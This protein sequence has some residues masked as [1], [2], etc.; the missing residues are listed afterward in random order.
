MAFYTTSA[1]SN[2]EWLQP[3]FFPSR[4]DAVILIA[5]IRISSVL[6]TI[7]VFKKGLAKKLAFIL[8]DLKKSRVK[9]VLKIS[10]RKGGQGVTTKTSCTTLIEKRTAKLTSLSRL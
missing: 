4:I 1:F 7:P 2:Q 8:S 10:A 9:G 5:I 6:L 3:Y